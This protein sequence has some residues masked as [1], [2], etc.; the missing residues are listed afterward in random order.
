VAGLAVA[1]RGEDPSEHGFLPLDEGDIIMVIRKQTD[2]VATPTGQPDIC[3]ALTRSC[4]YGLQP[5]RIVATTTLLWWVWFAQSVSSKWAPM[6]IRHPPL[7]LY[8]NPSLTFVTHMASEVPQKPV[9]AS[10]PDQAAPEEAGDEDRVGSNIATARGAD[11][12][13]GR[14]V[15]ADEEGGWWCNLQ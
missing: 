2:K 6:V 3:S 1:N 11:V 7:L 9:T 10:G 13:V 15:E 5:K 12:A 14:A 8:L 4:R